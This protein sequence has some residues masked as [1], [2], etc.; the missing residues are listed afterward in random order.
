MGVLFVLIFYFANAAANDIITLSGMISESKIC[1]DLI[2][3]AGNAHDIKI[4]LDTTWQAQDNLLFEVFARGL[5]ELK[6]RYAEFYAPNITRDSGYQLF[7]IN[8][9]NTTHSVIYANVIGQVTAVLF[10]NDDVAGGEWQFPRQENITVAPECGK[11]LLFPSSYTHPH[12]I[13]RI[14]IGVETFVVTSFF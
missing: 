9:A 6:R 1:T 7:R 12:L 10:L 8:E 3:K 13:K 14:R 4:S 2:A 5:V 11:M